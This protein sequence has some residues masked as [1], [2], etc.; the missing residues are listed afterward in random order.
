MQKLCVIDE[1]ANEK[2]IKSIENLGF[3]VLKAPAHPNLQGACKSHPDLSFCRISQNT[4]IY[5]KNSDAAFIQT[6]K[7]HGII[8][9]EGSTIPSPEYPYDIP[10]NGVKIGK[11]FLHNL[12]NTDLQVKEQ[13]QIEGLQ[14]KHVKQGYTCCSTAV[15]REDLVITADKG[16]A[17]VLEQTGEVSL[18]RIPPQTSIQLPE[19]DYGFLG[20]A[21]GRIDDTHFA[22]AGHIKY[23]ENGVE[24]Q[25]FLQK[26]GVQLINLTDERPV[27]LGTLLFFTL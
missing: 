6:L 24:I 9:I 23:L 14:M 20:G 7:Q 19:M 26:H 25:D 10:Y 8:M 18:L 16:I 17:E 5:A 3:Q 15:V 22:L 21:S 27:D 12:R 4:L 13:C 2:I 1:S 11:Y